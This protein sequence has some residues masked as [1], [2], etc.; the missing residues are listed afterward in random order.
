MRR[1]ALWTGVGTAILIV[2]VLTSRPGPAPLAQE[3]PNVFENPKNL[4]VLPEDISPRQL[5]DFMRS[6]AMGLGVRCWFCHVGE[7]G[8]DLSTFDFASDEKPHKAAAR[9]MF[10]MVMD[11]NGNH[12]SELAKLDMGH[13]DEE[14]AP[15]V[16]CVTC[17]AGEQKPPRD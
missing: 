15:S 3:G 12:L 6:A 13:D 14:E 7:E 16:R 1:R 4:K 9:I 8:Q 17:H 10:R 2:V 11:I 5:R